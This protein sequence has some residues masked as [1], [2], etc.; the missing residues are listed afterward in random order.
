MAASVKSLKLSSGQ[1]IPVLGMGTWQMGEN[2]RDRPSEVAALRHGLELGLSLIDTAEMYGEGGAELVIA[3]AIAGRR[4][5]VFLTSKVYP[6]N[7]SMKGAIA[8]CERS[9]KRLNT[10]YLDLYL[11]HWRSLVPLDETLGAFQKLHQAGKIRS[12]GVSNFDTQDMRKAVSIPGGKEIVTNQVL[13]N[14]MRR[15]VEWDLLPWCRQQNIP[16]MAYSPIE[17]G[18]LL[19][20]STLQKIAADRHATAAEV[21]IAWLLHQDQVIVIPKSSNIAHVEKNRAAL[22]L[23]LTIEEL[24][25][26]DTAF[27]PPRRSVPLEVL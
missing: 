6:H 3:E 9:L 1:A 20:D 8:A 11:L 14:L 22:D 23:R 2:D 21:A 24:E 5:D 7:A 12:Y 16:I 4:A 19:Q 17:Q 10:D 25:L 26:L 15:G 18:R 27:P 13:Y